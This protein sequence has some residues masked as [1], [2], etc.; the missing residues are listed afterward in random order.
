MA[1]TNKLLVIGKCLATPLKNAIKVQFTMQ[2]LDENLLMYFAKRRVLYAEDK[3][4]SCKPGDIVLIKRREQPLTKEITHEMV[5]IVYPVGDTTDPLTGK[6]T[7]GTELKEALEKKY[8]SLGTP[9]SGF[10]AKQS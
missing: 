5:R 10:L 9:L 3:T 7:I 2:E 6:K 1:A 8:K 4:G